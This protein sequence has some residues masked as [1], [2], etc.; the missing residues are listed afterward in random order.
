[1]ALDVGF[2]RIGVALSDP[3]RLTAHPFKIVYRK[4][5]RETFEELLKIIDE[6]KVDT[7]LVGIPFS[8][9]GRE[10]KMGE[11]IRKFVDR[12]KQFLKERDRRVSFVFVDE[13]YSTLEAEN[14]C[15][16]LG[17]KREEIDDIA[18]A[19]F[20]QEWLASRGVP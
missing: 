16:K 18:A 12:F 13:S 1:M 8:L 5:N 9:E 17:K 10:T 4:S 2:K 11:K 6:K 14:L 19:L 15:R 3:L 20:L 7:V